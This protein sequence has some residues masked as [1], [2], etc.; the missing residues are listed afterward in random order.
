MLELAYHNKARA[1]FGHL[2]RRLR[3][4]EMHA[5][6]DTLE[7]GLTPGEFRDLLRT[8]LFLTGLPRL[9]PEMSEIWLVVEISSVVDQNDVDRVERRA[10]LLRRAGYRALPV[11]AGE[12]MTRGAEVSARTQNVVLVQDGQVSFWEEA[13]DAWVA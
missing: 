11:A 5:V 1:Y 4:A 7:A 2:L 12:E 13:L 6:E 8:D 10:N 3:V 9:R